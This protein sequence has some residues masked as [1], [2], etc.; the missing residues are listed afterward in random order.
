MKIE[1][2]KPKDLKVGNLQINDVF[3]FVDEDQDDIYIMGTSFIYRI[4][5]KNG[6]PSHFSASDHHT[7]S[8]IKYNAELKLTVAE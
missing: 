8:V 3:S 1:I 5:S 6:T 2:R 4:F 7:M